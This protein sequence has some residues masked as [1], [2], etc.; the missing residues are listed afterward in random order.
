MFKVALA[1]FRRV[2]QV[3]AA[4]TCV[5]FA[6]PTASAQCS[7]TWSSTTSTQGG[8]LSTNGFVSGSVEWDPDG[9]GPEPSLYVIGGTFTSIDGVPS[10]NVAAFNRQTRGWQSIG[11]GTGAI[12]AGRSGVLVQQFVVNA[13]NELIAAV[14]Y[15][16]SSDD[17]NDF[18]YSLSKWNGTAWVDISPDLT[19]RCL[20]GGQSEC[21]CGIMKLLVLPNGDIVAGGAFGLVTG[22]QLSSNIARFN[23]TTWQSYA[24]GLPGNIYDLELFGGTTLIAA[25]TSSGA[26]FGGIARWNGTSWVNM[27]PG[28][29]GE[30]R[31]LTILSDGS[32]AVGGRFTQI[33]G[34]SAQNIA[35]WT[36]TVWSAFG[37]GVAIDTSV[38]WAFPGV[39]RSTVL[40]DGRLVVSEQSR[41]HA[42]NGT[43]WQRLPQISNGGAV[44]PIDLVSGP[45]GVLTTDRFVL[46]GS[47]WSP[48]SN[49]FDAPPQRF[50]PLAGGTELLATGAFMSVDG[51]STIGIA[52]RNAQGVWQ[53]LGTGLRAPGTTLPIAGRV[54]NVIEMA[55]GD[56]LVYGEFTLTGQP[57]DR[58]TLARWD[59]ATWHPFPVPAGNEFGFTSE[60][61]VKSA[62]GELFFGMRGLYRWTGSAWAQIPG[63]D[64]TLTHIDAMAFKPNGELIVAG[65]IRMG[66]NTWR[67]ASWNG[68]TWTGIGT[69]PATGIVPARLDD[70]AI[71]SDDLFY[72]GTDQGL[73]RWS[74]TSG[75]SEIL[76]RLRNSGQA[77][78]LTIMPDNRLLVTGDQ[79]SGG[80]SGGT[81]ATGSAIWDGTSWSALIG[82]NGQAVLDSFAT[83][84][85]ANNKIAVAVLLS[86]PFNNL[87]SLLGESSFPV[88]PSPVIESQTKA[89]VVCGSSSA[90]VSVSLQG[91]PSGVSAIWQVE[92][93]AGSW[94][95]FS[96]TPLNLVNGGVIRRSAGSG[97]ATQ[98][99]L[100]N[101]VFPVKVRAVIQ[102]PCSGTVTSLPMQVFANVADM[103]EQ[104]GFNGSDGIYDNNDFIVFID[105]FFAAD[106]GADIGSQGAAL[107][108]DGAFD[109]NDFIVFISQFFEGC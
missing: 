103:G 18:S 51:R 35:R 21:T 86:S 94:V 76:P 59:G 92:Q 29:I 13:S 37:S 26:S 73:F 107:G 84:V 23:G 16:T 61:I 34:V 56:L 5:L 79:L 30:V 72:V 46:D 81:L 80:P 2:A 22:N 48:L 32:L 12:A 53:P 1:N 99:F 15:L 55:N 47:S 104:G 90:A 24:N 82:P 96:E 52:R 87:T 17:N 8:N 93:A 20:C 100:S 65:E 63:L 98:V 78:Q 6:S 68:S 108:R 54:E 49:G 58:I 106:I 70:I 19:G 85:L 10:S 14:R 102:A 3:L 4:A 57:S 75:L 45:N 27:N 31:S 44:W 77:Y 50:F 40:S 109:N 39:W 74:S 71:V 67:I 97:L 36:G 88:I 83:T 95:A 64:T 91:E 11:M 9:A 41:L 60:G 101:R 43:T 105:R 69:T 62:S 7:G 33:A 42:W 66:A 89:A 28:G 38:W 25:G